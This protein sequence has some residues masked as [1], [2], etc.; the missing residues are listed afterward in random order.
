VSLQLQDLQRAGGVVLRVAALLRER[1]DVR[2]GAGGLRLTQAPG[3]EFERV[4]FAYPGED[5][6]R[7]TKD[8]SR[9]SASGHSSFV[10]GSSSDISHPG[11]HPALDGVS[12]RL[13]PGAVLGVVGR[14]GSGKT[15]LAR[16]LFRLYDPQTGT[17]RL[18]GTDLRRFRLAELRRSVG[19]VTQE[20][21]LFR[22]TVRDNLTFFDPGVPD[23]RLHN[24]L[25]RVGLEEWLHA[26]PGGLD[27]ETGGAG[28]LSAGQA[29]LLAFARVFLRDPAVVILD[30]ASSR[31]D[32]A[33][34]A[35][36]EQALDALLA[37]RTGIVIAHRVATVR[38]ADHIL[39]L[40][41]GR[42]VE[43]GPR[44][45]LEADTTSRFAA[46]LRAGA[47]TSSLAWDRL[48]IPFGGLE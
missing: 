40:E 16:L 45:V 2:D 18:G 37:G 9:P 25:G 23:A 27:G 15:T 34:E 1:P 47:R 46:L 14:T 35:Q 28:A 13:A 8:E 12:F 22:G 36:V 5:E 29:Q 20:V 24:V 33:T 7:R 11:S 4:T 39:V 17:I 44:A 3:V 30:E 19:L 31:L 41:H 6:R 10:L 21:Q 26:L 32:P 42:V 48:A 38:R 43:C